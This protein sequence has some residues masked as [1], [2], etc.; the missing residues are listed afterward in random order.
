M[1]T[2]CSL[3]VLDMSGT[4]PKLFLVYAC[5][6]KENTT[7]PE[8]ACSYKYCE[9][10]KMA[11]VVDFFSTKAILLFMQG[12]IVFQVIILL[13]IRYFLTNLAKNW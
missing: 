4:S 7:L 8:P 9:K 6:N 12:R 13:F 2:Y 11:W 1:P 10:C 3:G 5:M